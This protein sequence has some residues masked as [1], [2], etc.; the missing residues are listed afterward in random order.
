MPQATTWDVPQLADAPQTPAAMWAR[1]KDMLED[2]VRS[3]HSGATRPSYAVE[4]TVWYDTDVDRLFLY[5]GTTDHE[6]PLLTRAPAIVGSVSGTNTITGS[7]TPAITAYSQLRLVLILWAGANTGA[8][9]LNLN[10]LGA[11]S[12]VK[13][14]ATALASS[15][16]A[17]GRA[18][19][20]YWDNTNDRFQVVGL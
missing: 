11:K 9:T 15:D 10:S 8:V 4:G 12:V 16:L 20:L 13:A 17:T 7:I 1:I 5:D 14:N 18:D 3:S 19:I 2:A 6:L